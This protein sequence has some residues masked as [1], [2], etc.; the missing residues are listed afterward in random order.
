MECSSQAAAVQQDEDRYYRD[1]A[2]YRASSIHQN[3]TPP[4]NHL[5]DYVQDHDSPMY[6]KQHKEEDPD[7]AFESV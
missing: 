4:I 1:E 2:D 5:I 6:G 7:D 3:Y